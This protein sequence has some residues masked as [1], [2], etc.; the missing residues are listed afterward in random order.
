V[1]SVGRFDALP[2]QQGGHPLEKKKLVEGRSV[3]LL[4]FEPGF[5]DPSWCE[6]SHVFYVVAGTLDLEL[7]GGEIAR[8]CAGECAVLDRGTRHRARNAGAAPLTLFVVSDL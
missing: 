2:W 8:M 1:I 4:R 3:A 6:R 5:A 7:D